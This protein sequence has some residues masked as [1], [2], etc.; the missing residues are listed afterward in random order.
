MNKITCDECASLQVI[1]IIKNRIQLA[2][3]KKESATTDELESFWDGQTRCAQELLNQI[4][5]VLFQT[6]PPG[7]AGHIFG[8][9]RKN[10]P[11]TPALARQG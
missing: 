7:E 8:Q 1:D 3:Q 11:T 2:E 10:E 4:H 9:M 5:R 6:V